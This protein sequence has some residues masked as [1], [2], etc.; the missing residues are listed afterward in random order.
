MEGYIFAES[1]FGKEGGQRGVSVAAVGGQGVF[2][3]VGCQ[4]SEKRGRMDVEKEGGR[5]A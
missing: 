1:V 5:G 2:H 4:E 3:W